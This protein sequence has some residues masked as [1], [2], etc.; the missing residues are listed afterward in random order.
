MNSTSYIVI[1]LIVIIII[2]VYF[3][4]AASLKSSVKT[5]TTLYNLNKQNAAIISSDLTNPLSQNFSYSVWIFVNTWNTNSKK[6]I[7]STGSNSTISLDLGQTNPTLSTT[8]FYN[9]SN[10]STPATNIT[11]TSNF[12]IQK[13]VYVV[14]SVDSQTVDCYLDGKLVASR[15][16]P[17]VPYIPPS[18]SINFGSFDAYLTGFK[19]TDKPMNPQQVWSNYMAGNGYSGGKYGVNLA[20]TK[21]SAVI[22]QISY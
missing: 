6:T 9:P 10:T 20:L 5:S 14:V 17:N 21:D 18:Y 13:W 15:Q 4:Y 7:Y 16:L 1:V 2:M 19:Y 11:I 3:L 8:I 12:P 22:G